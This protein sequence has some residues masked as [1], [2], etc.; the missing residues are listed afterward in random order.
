[1]E[2]LSQMVIPESLDVQ[3]IVFALGRHMSRALSIV[4]LEEEAVKE[5]SK[6]QIGQYLLSRDMEELANEIRCTVDPETLAQVVEDF[7]D[8]NP[9]A[10]IIEKF[11]SLGENLKKKLKKMKE[12]LSNSSSALSPEATSPKETTSSAATPL[13]SAART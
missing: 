10:S 3:S 11:G 12:A 13:K 1:M 6:T 5:K 4:L 2:L 7:F 8:C 9:I